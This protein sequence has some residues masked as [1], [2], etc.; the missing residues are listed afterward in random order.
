MNIPHK[1]KAIYPSGE[2]SIGNL[3]IKE[4]N[5]HYRKIDTSTSEDCILI[6]SENCYPG[7]KAK[8]DGKS[9]PIHKRLSTLMA[10]NLPKGKHVIELTFQPF[11]FKL[12]CYI[13]NIAIA[14]ISFFTILSLIQTIKIENH[15]KS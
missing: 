15:D 10:I 14:I 12:G 1:I 2:L 8:L 5:N 7:W 6:D 9:I 4:F 3:E 11:S 13:S